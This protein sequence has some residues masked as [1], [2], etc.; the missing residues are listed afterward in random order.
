MRGFSTWLSRWKLSRVRWGTSFSSSI[1]STH[2]FICLVPLALPCLAATSGSDSQWT[3]SHCLLT[4]WMLTNS[5]WFLPNHKSH[6][7]WRCQVQVHQRSVYFKFFWKFSWLLVA[8]FLLD[9]RTSS[10]QVGRPRRTE[11]YWRQV[12]DTPPSLHMAGFPCWLATN[13]CRGNGHSLGLPWLTTQLKW[14]WFFI[15]G[16]CSCRTQRFP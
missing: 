12:V 9:G 15:A 8:W 2:C 16:G 5:H 4:T 7:T 13:I 6:V 3:T 1:F 11:P 10:S 14:V